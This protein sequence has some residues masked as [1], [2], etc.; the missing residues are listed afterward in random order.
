MRL[1]DSC[2][3]QVKAH[4]PSRTCHES[5][6][7][8]E[9]EVLNTSALLLEEHWEEVMQVDRCRGVVFHHLHRKV[10]IRLPGKWHSNFH[11]ARPVYSS[12]LDDEVDSDQ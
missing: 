3:T 4:G 1:I 5:K 10:D 2:I 8:E 9:E 12:H 11:G 7:Q 6:F